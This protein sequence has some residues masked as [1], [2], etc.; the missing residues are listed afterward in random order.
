MRSLPTCIIILTIKLYLSDK[1]KKKSIFP[2]LKINT[3]YIT[4]LEILAHVSYNYN[5]MFTIP[6]SKL[7][8]SIKFQ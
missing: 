6:K 7:P 8:I 3:K 4:V 5:N 1:R 2:M